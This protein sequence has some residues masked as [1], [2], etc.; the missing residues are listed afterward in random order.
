MEACVLEHLIARGYQVRHR[1][2]Y[3]VDLYDADQVLLTNALMGCV[4]AVTLDGNPLSAPT[5]LPETINDA[6]FG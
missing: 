6:I 3:P 5:P 2:L 1:P 4:P